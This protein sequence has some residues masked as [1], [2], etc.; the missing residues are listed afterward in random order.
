MLFQKIARFVKNISY[1]MLS[2]QGEFLQKR[3]VKKLGYNPKAVVDGCTVDIKQEE[4]DNLEK[5]NNNVKAILKKCENNPIKLLEYFKENEVKYC[6]I[7]YAKRLLKIIGETEGLITER[8]G[9]RGLAINILAGKGI[10]FK[11]EPLIVLEKEEEPDIYKLINNFYKWYSMKEGLKGFDEKS[12]K[13]LKKFTPKNEDKLIKKLS[14]EEISKL[15]EAI[16][17]DV[18]AIEFVS[19]YSRENAGSKKALEKIQGD[20]GA[21]I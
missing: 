1:M 5:I 12:Q 19:I 6:F 11:T 15:K 18:Q 2:W 4:K 13:L 17:R 9:V 14:L 3:L 16:A 10:R 20:K 8:T 21:S 7:K